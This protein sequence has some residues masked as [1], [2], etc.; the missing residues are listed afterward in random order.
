[1]K[2]T[3]K[4]VVPKE[5]TDFYDALTRIHLKYTEE[6]PPIELNTDEQSSSV[7]QKV[8]LL[9]F[10]EFKPDREKVNQIFNEVCQVLVE[11]RPQF[12]GD[13]DKIKAELDVPDQD[14]RPL[15]EQFVWQN[16]RYIEDY[17]ADKNLNGE[18]L[19]LI[20]FNVAK[21]LVT[22]FARRVK[23]QVLFDQWYQKTCPVCGWKPAMAIS[24][25]E[26]KKRLLHCS[27]CDTEWSFKNLECPHCSNEDHTTLK[28]LTIEGDEV[29][30]INV[31]DKCKGYI[32]TIDKS[33]VAAKGD[34]I[35]EDIITLHLD[36]IAQREGYRKDVDDQSSKELN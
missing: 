14:L 16:D 10:V 22:E 4:V 1:M 8:P 6:L 13:V 23:D 7:E 28:Y 20:L 36:I 17:L 3:D 15:L 19:S 5:I 9:N 35:S 29:Y 33:K 30:N 34:N 31:C 2:I 21:P 24:A 11:H 12:T 32:K 26:D 18:I 25:V 27:L